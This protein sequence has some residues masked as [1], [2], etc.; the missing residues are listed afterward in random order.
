MTVRK[1]KTTWNLDKHRILRKFVILICLIPL[2]CLCDMENF[3]YYEFSGSYM[4]DKIHGGLFSDFLEKVLKYGTKATFAI[5]LIGIIL[6]IFAYIGKLFENEMEH[7]FHTMGL[8]TCTF[9]GIFFSYIVIVIGD[10]YMNWQGME[11]LF[12][13]EIM[14]GIILSIHSFI[15][16]KNTHDEFI[17]VKRGTKIVAYLV[18]GILIVGT[19]VYF[20]IGIG[21]DYAEVLEVKKLIKN[22]RQ[23]KAQDIEHQMGNYSTGAAVYVDGDL[24][25]LDKGDSISK[26]DEQGKKETIYQALEGVD[27]Q[28][29][30][31]YYNKGYLYYC[32]IDGDLY[33][34]VRTATEDG[35]T[36]DIITSGLP[37]YFGIVEDEL[38]YI[39]LTDLNHFKK[40]ARELGVD[41]AEKVYCLDL[42]GDI[43]VANAKV[44]DKSVYLEYSHAYWLTRYLYNNCYE[45]WKT[46]ENDDY[47]RPV[48]QPYSDGVFYLGTDSLEDGSL[49]KIVRRDGQKEYGDLMWRWNTID[50]EVC[51]YNIFD[52]EIYYMRENTDGTYELWSCDTE[53]ENKNLISTISIKDRY[54]YSSGNE[55]CTRI[56]LSENYVVCDFAA[57]PVGYTVDERYVIRISDGEI[58]K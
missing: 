6:M 52:G 37:L 21:K 46:C 2:W 36:E 45:Y 17:Q 10:S 44:Y 43:N 4:E 19:L 55:Y 13:I 24:Y 18:V 31:L 33:K 29:R 54:D 49:Y 27:I 28:V 41:D 34:I 9:A 32:V 48:E 58:I 53:G 42:N 7:R 23:E 56:Y 30:G 8:A 15:S 14:L 5:L 11:W 1:Q 51:A 40:N 26:I 25:L 39:E 3:F 12:L 16:F 38:Y 50:K 47:I 22:Q 20:G 35:V 57:Y